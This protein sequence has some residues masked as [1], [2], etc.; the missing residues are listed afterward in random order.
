MIPEWKCVPREEINNVW[1]LLRCACQIKV[2]TLCFWRSSKLWT[3]YAESV[4]RSQPLLHVIYNIFWPFLAGGSKVWIGLLLCEHYGAC[5]HPCSSV[6][7]WIH[8]LRS[9]QIDLCST[10][11]LGEVDPLVW[12]KSFGYRAAIDRP[13]HNTL[14]VLIILKRAKILK[15]W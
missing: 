11:S 13:F 3:T 12:A 1:L 4:P 2:N 15:G 8:P 5:R 7:V 10:P 6:S 14:V 9:L